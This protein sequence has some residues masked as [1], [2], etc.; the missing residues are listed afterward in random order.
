[1]CDNAVDN[2]VHPLEFVPDCYWTRK[3]F[4]KAVNTLFSAKHFVPEC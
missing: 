4:N 2:Y 3:M 1:M